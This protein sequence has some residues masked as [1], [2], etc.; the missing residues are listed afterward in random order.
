M[1]RFSKWVN[2]K[3]VNNTGTVQVLKFIKQIITDNGHPKTIKTDNASCFKSKSYIRFL[4]SE[5]INYE[6]VTPYVHTGNGTVERTI[7][8]IDAY[9]KIFIDENFSFQDTAL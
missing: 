6:Y 3:A 8:T 9:L 4:E 2:I 7:G 1:D 5:G